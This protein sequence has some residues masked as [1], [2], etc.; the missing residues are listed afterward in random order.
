[1]QVTDIE[2]RFKDVFYQ[3]KLALKQIL[4]IHAHRE[5]LV[6][7]INIYLI[8]SLSKQEVEFLGKVFN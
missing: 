7:T 1:M 3:R 5:L 2:G 6:K 8:Y 4:I